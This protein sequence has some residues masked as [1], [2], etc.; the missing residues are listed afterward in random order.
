VTGAGWFPDRLEIREEGLV[1]GDE[2][3]QER[4]EDD[5]REHHDTDHG[6]PMAKKS[7]ERRPSERDMLDGD[8]LRRREIDD[9]SLRGQA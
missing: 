9:L 5:D 3:R 8:D 7:P 1:V 2:G 6:E 4:S